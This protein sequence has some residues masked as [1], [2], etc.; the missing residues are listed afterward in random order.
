MK[1]EE[2][3][4]RDLINYGYALSDLCQGF[5]AKTEHFLVRMFIV[6]SVKKP[7]N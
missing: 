1:C 3:N 2:T 6:G 7:R 5:F 4:Q